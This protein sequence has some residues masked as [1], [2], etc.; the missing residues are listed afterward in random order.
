VLFHGRENIQIDVMQKNAVTIPQSVPLMPPSAAISPSRVTIRDIAQRAKASITTVS[1]ALHGKGRVSE[2]QRSR[3]QEIAREMGYQPKLAAQLLRANSTGHVG[4]ILPGGEVTDV[5]ESGHAGPI[6]A[7]FI[8]TCEQRGLRYHIEFV[9]GD[10]EE[11]FEP[12][13]QLAGGLVDGVLVGG[14]V[15][16]SLRTWL[17]ERSVTW[18]SVDEPSEYCVLSADDEGL[19][20]ATERLAALGHRRVAYVGGPLRYLSHRQALEGFQR[21]ADEFHLQTDGR[22]WLSF[23]DDK[24]RRDL[25]TKGA[26]WAAD[27]LS[28]DVRPSAIVCHNMVVARGIIHQAQRMGLDVPGDVSVIAVGLGADAEKNLPC[29]TTVEVDF[30]TLVDHAMNVLLRKLDGERGLEKPQ[31]KRVRPHLVMRDTVA[32]PRR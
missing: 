4:L 10:E 17:G 28:R 26:T 3:I 14:Y 21:A 16:E 24:A 12:P 31:T 23:F 32:P 20:E 27:V 13:R 5:S 19:Y 9:E 7:H 1:S 22:E 11:F 8:R 18:V 15:S 25:L 29:L 6:L 30:A 2:A